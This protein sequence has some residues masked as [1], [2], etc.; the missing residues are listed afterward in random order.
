MTA[1]HEAANSREKGRKTE[2][3]GPSMEDCR[4]GDATTRRADRRQGQVVKQSR[5]AEVG[6][7]FRNFSVELAGEKN[8]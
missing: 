2:T 3:Q 8:G 4:D 5:R 7:T 1:R 6:G